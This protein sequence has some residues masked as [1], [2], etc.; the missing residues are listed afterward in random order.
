M[1][2]YYKISYYWY[3]WEWGYGY[4]AAQCADLRVASQAL[5]SVYVHGAA[6]AHRAPTRV[7]ESEHAILL[8]KNL[9]KGVKDSHSWFGMDFE[10]VVTRFS[11][12]LGIIP[13]NS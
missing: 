1:Q 4:F 13:L 2:I 9:E 11:V 10:H 7:S 5:T 12:C 3:V 8:L 6:S